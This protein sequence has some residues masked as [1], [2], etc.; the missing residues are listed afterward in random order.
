[1]IALPKPVEERSRAL[2]CCRRTLYQIGSIRTTKCPQYE[3]NANALIVG[4]M[5]SLPLRARTS[6]Y[7]T[8]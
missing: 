6:V 2:Y 1:M 8:A 7:Y 5:A 4:E 3:S